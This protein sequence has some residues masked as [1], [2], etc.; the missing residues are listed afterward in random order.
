MNFTARTLVPATERNVGGLLDAIHQLCVD[1][2][3]PWW[4]CASP[5][6]PSRRELDRMVAEYPTK[7][8]VVAYDDAGALAGYDFHDQRGRILGGQHRHD[9]ANLGYSGEFTQWNRDLQAAL[10]AAIGANTGGQVFHVTVTNPRLR[11]GL[12]VVCAIPIYPGVTDEPVLDAAP[13]Y[14][15]PPPPA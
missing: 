2:Y 1:Y 4:A 5:P 6:Y 13:P 10:N 11:Y 3:R 14:L 9:P 7:R 12:E 15:G 8:F